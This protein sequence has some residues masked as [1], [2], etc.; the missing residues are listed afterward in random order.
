MTKKKSAKRAFLS[1][2]L[3]LSLCFTMLVGTTFAWYTDSVTSSGNKIIAGTLDIQL[4]KYNG[5]SYEDISASAAPIFKSSNYATNSTETLWEPGKT[6]IAYLKIVN[7]GDLW[8]KYQVALEVYNVSKNLYKAM[9]YEIVPDAQGGSLD[10]LSWTTLGGLPPVSIAGVE[11]PDDGSYTFGTTSVDVPMA[12]G[13]VHY[14]ALA[15]HMDEEAGNEYMNGEVDFDLKVLATQ[16]TAEFDSFSNQ[17]DYLSAYPEIVSGS[18]VYSTTQPTTVTAGNTDNVGAAKVTIPAGTA[19]VGDTPLA[20][21]ENVNLYVE[22]TDTPAN[23]EVESESNGTTTYEVGL[24]TDSGAK[25]TSTGGVFTVDLNIGVVNLQNFAHKGEAMESVD[26]INDL[27]NGKYYYNQSTGIITFM[28]TSFSPFTSEY[29]FDGGLGTEDYPYLIATAAQWNDIRT[30]EYFKLV[31]D[32]DFKGTAPTAKN[33]YSSSKSTIILGDNHVIKNTSG[34]LFTNDWLYNLVMKDLTIKNSYADTALI[35]K[36][37]AYS[38]NIGLEFDN[39]D[40]E[41]CTSKGG[42]FFLPWVY[43]NYNVSFKNCDVKSSNLYDN[44]AQGFTGVFTGN[45]KATVLVDNCSLT[46]VYIE[47]FKYSCGSFVSGYSGGKV[48]NSTVNA[49]TTIVQK[50]NEVDAVAIGGTVTTIENCEF[51]GTIK[52][53]KIGRAKFQGFEATGVWSE[54][55]PSVVGSD[56]VIGTDGTVTYNGT[57]SFSTVKVYQKVNI[58]RLFNGEKENGGF[59]YQIGETTTFTNVSN[60]T[61]MVNAIPYITAFKN[62]AP[63]YSNVLKNSVTSLPAGLSFSGHGFAIDNGTAYLDASEGESSK[64]TD[65]VT[66]THISSTVTKTRITVFFAVYDANDTLVSVASNT[67]DVII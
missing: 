60:G 30:A 6:Q 29:L 56:F 13:D 27:A 17:Y 48:M 3:M 33:G 26:D 46:D 24:E 65:Y 44:G 21:N 57:G 20:D 37:G 49:G 22:E 10:G 38:S 28:T 18:A 36:Y 39:V 43:E 9:R 25:I 50:N 32:I 4:W 23:F 64:R 1:S 58:D 40:I 53:E 67:Y 51:Y 11:I 35:G 31:D 45:S 16:Q 14:F 52:S 66:G 41:E 62:V 8:L 12:P 2:L 54:I 47:A 5:T 15:I 34:S 55:T 63:E 19:Y 7:G 42:S 61:E 59:P